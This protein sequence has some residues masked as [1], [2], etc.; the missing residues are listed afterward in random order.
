M[1][2]LFFATDLHGSDI[3]FRKFIGAAKYY[4]VDVLILGGDITGKMIVPIVRQRDD[5]FRAEFLGNDIVVRSKEEYDSLVANIQLNGMYPYETDATEMEKLQTDP[6]LVEK[7]FTKLMVESIESW[8]NF[9]EEKLRGTKVRM[10]ITGG[11]DDRLDVDQILKA[12][13]AEN[14]F[15][16]DGNVVRID[17]FHEMI[18]CSYSNPTPWKTP[19]EV[20]EEELEDM[21]D[22]MVSKVED[23]Q[24]CIFNL[25]IPPIDSGLD[26]CPKLD[27]SVFP[28]KPMLEK[29]TPIMFGAGSVAVRNAI[30]KY[31]PL[32]GLHGHIH[33]S[34]GVR[35]LGR[36]LCINP[37]SEYS[38]GF[39]R[40][41]IV[42][43]AEKKIRGYQLTS[44]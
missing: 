5:T 16:P 38:Q 6:E 18:N 11:N 29:G 30:E 31:Q 15:D 2:R 8:F 33:E 32:L 36:T 12:R 13:K 35:R 34:R 44:G 7:L 17:E 1:T 41:V 25:H 19:R 3:C 27:V 23:I 22:R 28:P 4:D 37:G 20:S 43:V 26:T 21:I 24:N 42:T 9:A 10:F 40:G 14:V 39:V